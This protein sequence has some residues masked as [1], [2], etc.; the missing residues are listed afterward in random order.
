[1]ALLPQIWGFQ[2]PLLKC[3]GAAGPILDRREAFRHISGC[4]LIS[5]NLSMGV[6]DGRLAADAL[7]PA[8]EAADARVGEEAE[9]EGP[10]DILGPLAETMVEAGLTP[11]GLDRRRDARFRCGVDGADLDP[12]PQRTE[13]AAAGAAP[14]AGRQAHDVLRGKGHATQ[15]A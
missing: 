13:R 7:G 4:R 5:D 8:I 12:H 14:G 10:A 9:Q 15:A 3:H 2:R 1:V 11:P 6:E